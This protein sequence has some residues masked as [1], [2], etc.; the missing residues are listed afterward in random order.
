[1]PNMLLVGDNN[2]K[3]ADATMRQAILQA[4]KDAAA[5]NKKLA[6]QQA[7]DARKSFQDAQ[8]QFNKAADDMPKGE[9]LRSPV[10]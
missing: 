8:A 3:L 2:A 5:E 1:M 6:Q 10:R 4:Q 9:S 7:D